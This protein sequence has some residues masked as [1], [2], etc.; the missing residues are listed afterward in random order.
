MG[1]DQIDE[2]NK[3][4]NIFIEKF[5]SLSQQHQKWFY[6]AA[7]ECDQEYETMMQTVTKESE[8]KWLAEIQEIY[9][10]QEKVQKKAANPHAD[11]S[12]GL[13]AQN[14]AGTGRCGDYTT[15]PRQIQGGI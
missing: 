15:A 9:R 12:K 6:I 7:C 10:S 4:I 11:Q 2:Q 13:T 14:T 3:I 1:K 5:Q 8:R